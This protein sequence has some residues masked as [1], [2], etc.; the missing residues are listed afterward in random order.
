MYPPAPPVVARLRSRC[1][2]RTVTSARLRGA[3]EMPDELPASVAVATVE[4]I[5]RRG[6]NAF[7]VED[8]AKFTGLDPMTI[9]DR[10][11]DEE[12]LAV[13]ALCAHYEATI[14]IPDTGSFRDD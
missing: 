7:T 5:R 6:M 1:I 14:P 11:G 3:H 12:E 9:R 13:R 8:V 10:W 4:S 2:H